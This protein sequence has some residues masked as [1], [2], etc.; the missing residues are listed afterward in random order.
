M[1]V[2]V[3][4]GAQQNRLAFDF[5]NAMR[6]LGERAR[7]VKIGG[8]GRNALDF[9]LTFYLG[10]LVQQDP[11]GVFG[12][13]SK[14]SGFD[15]LIVHLQARGIDLERLEACPSAGGD[16]LVLADRETG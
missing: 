13:V 6:A 8:S 9:H 4:V 11:G 12:V 7:Y 16:L 1:R 2:L 15:P 5:A 14:D 10:E 3:F